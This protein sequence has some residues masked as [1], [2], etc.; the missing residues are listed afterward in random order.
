MTILSFLTS[1]FYSRECHTTN[2]TVGDLSNT[3]FLLLV[4]KMNA[5]ENKHLLEIYAVVNQLTLRPKKIIHMFVIQGDLV[6]T[7]CRGL[8]ESNL[9]NLQQWSQQAEKRKRKKRKKEREQDEKQNFL[10]LGDSLRSSNKI[11]IGSQR[12]LFC[13][14]K[15]D[16]ME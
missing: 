8:T 3:C 11:F 7:F 2:A 6:S 9:A 13:Q 1:N 14:Q 4:N 5:T 12:S 10:V 15:E 16:I